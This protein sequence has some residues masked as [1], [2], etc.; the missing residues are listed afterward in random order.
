[1]LIIPDYL[2]SPLFMMNGAEHPPFLPHDFLHLT[3]IGGSHGYPRTAIQM[4]LQIIRM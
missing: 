2:K 4:L 3:K 1:M